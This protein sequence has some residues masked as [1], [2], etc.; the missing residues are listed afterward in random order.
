[1]AVTWVVSKLAK[2]KFVK[3]SQLFNISLKVKTKLVPIWGKLRLVREP[4]FVNRF[5]IASTLLVFKLGIFSV[6]KEWQFLKAYD[7]S[8]NETWSKWSKST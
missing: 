8:V 5:I 3:D 7:I 6:F 4:Q 2:L 1:M